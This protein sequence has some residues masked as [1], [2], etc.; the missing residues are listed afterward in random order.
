MG[1]GKS[2]Q[3][4]SRPVWAVAVAATLAASSSWAAA[5]S[6]FGS[7][8]GEGP[9]TE[10]G[11]LTDGPL[12][13]AGP[14]D[15]AVPPLDCDSGPLVLC[16]DFE[17]ALGARWTKKLVSLPGALQLLPATPPAVSQVLRVSVA[18][19]AGVGTATLTNEFVL[20][21]S[22]G[23]TCDLDLT[24]QGLPTPPGAR[25]R[26]FSFS[27]AASATSEAN[28]LYGYVS[29]DTKGSYVVTQLQNLDRVYV[30]GPESSKAPFPATGASH[31]TLALDLDSETFSMA[32]NGVPLHSITL[33]GRM[34]KNNGVNITLGADSVDSAVAYDVDNVVC[35]A[36]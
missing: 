21:D 17:G 28:G 8:D 14:A 10:A 12:T 2:S 11:I 23:F 16:D 13:D 33:A 35:R 31:L 1:E 3:G 25:P 29:L 36:R 15:A 4:T 7:S 27:V 32:L 24:P 9:P 26:L 18:P 20:V 6:S 22:R 30:S 34:R 5:C 19:D